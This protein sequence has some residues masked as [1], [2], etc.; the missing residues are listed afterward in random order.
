MGKDNAVNMK[1]NPTVCS[2]PSFD[3][4]IRQNVVMHLRDG[5]RLAA[6]IYLPA[7]GG[8]PAAER[9]PAILVRT[10]YNKTNLSDFRYF[11]ERGYV[12]VI[13]DVRGRYASEGT[14]YPFVN[15][16]NDGYDTIEWITSQAWCNGKVGTTGSSYAAAA[17][18]A[19]AS[20][21]PPGLSAM[22][23]TFGPSSYFHCAMRHNG[24][25]EMLFVVYAFNMAATSREAAADP[26][27]KTELEKA[28]E[29]IWHWVKLYPIRKGETPL[30]LVPSYEQW[31]IDVS[32]SST[33]D[34]YWRRPGYGPRP[35]Y[36]IHADVPSLY[37]GG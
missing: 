37:I 23:V 7:A 29:N 28:L 32:T 9:L 25:F 31:L 15:E 12:V 27:I 2:D 35:F 19:A 24:A 18:S 17:Q 26:H 30:A 11:A 16:G 3:V 36:D 21:N 14:F 20:L 4:S 8:R 6:D 1:V 22:V 33:Y 34:D 10:P 5:V 13:Q